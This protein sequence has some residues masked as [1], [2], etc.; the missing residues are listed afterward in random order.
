[1]AR[2]AAL[3]GPRQVGLGEEV[4]LVDDRPGDLDARPLEERLVE[5]D[6]VDRPADTAF[7]DDDRRRPEHGRDV[8]I[9]EVDDG[10]RP[11]R[12]RSPRSGACRGPRRTR[13]A[14]RGCAPARSST[15]LPSMWAWVNP[16]GMWTGLIRASGSGRSKTVL[17]RTASSSAGTPSSMTVRWPTGLQKPGREAAPP[18]AVED[19]EADRGLAAV[20]AGRGEVEVAHHRPVR[21]PA[22]RAVAG[23][24]VG[25]SLSRGRRSCARRARSR[26]AA[27]PR[28]RR[29][30]HRTR[31]TGRG[32]P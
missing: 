11:R 4:D 29:P 9:R 32:A 5:H 17:M 13:R 21:G 28:S 26:R 15:T 8:G 23:G 2:E 12:A 7:G 25:R 19:P 31:G 10:A 16:R 6:L 22:H 18:E 30:R 27:A 1:M 20:L 24:P 3:Q 14:R